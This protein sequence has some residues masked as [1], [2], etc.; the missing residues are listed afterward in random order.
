MEQQLNQLYRTLYPERTLKPVQI[1]ILENLIN[2]KDTVAILATG[3]GKS[4]CFQLPFLYFKKTIIVISPL[5]ALMED[6][7]I[8]LN[9]IGIPSLCFN[10]N[11]SLQDKEHHKMEIIDCNEHKILYMTPEYITREEIFIKDLVKEDKL[12]LIAID[13]AHCIS[14]WGHDFRKDFQQLSCLKDWTQGSNIPIFAC[15]ATATP[16]VEKDILHFLQL[17]NPI[18]VKSSFDRPNLFIECHKKSS[19]IF[20]DIKP[21]LDKFHNDCIIIYAKTREDTETICAIVKKLNITCEAYNGGMT[22]K[23]RKNIHNGFV[24]GLYKCIVA[25]VAFG[26]G[27]DQN[28]RLIIHYGV[29]SDMES[30]NQ[31]IGRAGRDGAESNCVLFWS[32]QDF[33]ISRILL[34]D[35]SDEKYRK[36]KESQIEVMTKWT[37]TN[38]CRKKIILKHFGEIM[39]DPCMKCD[40]CL[41]AEKEKK[42]KYD[43]GPL[44]Y[45]MYLIMKTMFTINKRGIGINKIVD[46]LRG[47]KSKSIADLQN[48]ATFSAGYKYGIDF[49]KELIKL[50]IF[51][52]HLKEVSL[53][54]KYGT[55]IMTTQ[56]TV[57]WWNVARKYNLENEMN[58]IQWPQ[59]D[60]PSSFELILN[61]LPRNNNPHDIEK[62]KTD[63]QKTLD[64]FNM[65][66]NGRSLDDGIQ[67]LN[68]FDEPNKINRPNK[69]ILQSID[70]RTI[71]I[72][73]SK[74]KKIETSSEDNQNKTELAKS[75]PKTR[76]KT[77]SKTT[78]NEIVILPNNIQNVLD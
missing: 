21:F 39:N 11:M 2:G 51:N 8:N 60:I 15:T 5:I 67:E 43:Q 49:L 24:D 73:Q 14:T 59:F 68:T 77:R 54:K 52:E 34:K 36:F 32:N 10:S 76:S 53:E 71:K 6:Q 58:Y 66:I 78:I 61:Y 18:V 74:T 9:K 70:I 25:T 48:T 57:D 27:I 40:N 20:L 17:F 7:Q 44:Y 46:I 12:C 35:I 4:I 64:L 75:K 45:P 37:Q 69:S 50:L 47:S 63:L 22:P 62:R 42:R 56:N 29:P 19:D 3:A 31:E 33:M 65:D 26:M 38:I 28:V 23:N 30:Y 1:K 13:E 41:N 55:I 72:A 16:K